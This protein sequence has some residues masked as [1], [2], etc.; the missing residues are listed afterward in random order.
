MTM[1]DEAMDL[2]YTIAK[3][4]DE[5]QGLSDFMVTPNKNEDTIIIEIGIEDAHDWMRT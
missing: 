3:Y 1:S 5:D 2:I 4:L